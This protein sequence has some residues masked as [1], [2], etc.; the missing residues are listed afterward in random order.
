[1]VFTFLVIFPYS[2]NQIIYLFLTVR[3]DFH[4]VFPR[5]WVFY[6]YD[7]NI[8]SSKPVTNPFTT[9]IT[10]ATSFGDTHLLLHLTFVMNKSIKFIGA[11][12]ADHK[13]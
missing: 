5:I 12:A 11:L 8:I 1:M 9:P 13:V 3:T 4:P 6:R 7:G 2:P 10:L